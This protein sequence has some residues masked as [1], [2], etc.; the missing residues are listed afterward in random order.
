M[1]ESRAGRHSGITYQVSVVS[2]PAVTHGMTRQ[3]FTGM[4]IRA[5]NN[6]KKRAPMHNYAKRPLRPH[7]GTHLKNSIETSKIQ[8]TLFPKGAVL[9]G[10]VASSKHYAYF[11]DQGTKPFMAKVLPPWAPG[12]PTLFEHTWTPPGSQRPVGKKLVRG[13]DAQL[14]FMHGLDDT[15]KGTKLTG[16]RAGLN[17]ASTLASWPHG[18]EHTNGSTTATPWRRASFIKRLQ[19]W[20]EWRDASVGEWM[21]EQREAKAERKL[22]AR[23]RAARQAEKQRLAEKAGKREADRRRQDE[24]AIAKVRQALKPSKRRD[25]LDEIQA[26]RDWLYHEFTKENEGSFDIRRLKTGEGVG[27][28]T[29]GSRE[30]PTIIGWARLAG[31][32]GSQAEWAKKRSEKKK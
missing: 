25:A 5:K 7:P 2:A 12:S 26:Y 24:K 15:M 28:R 17:M 18:L 30:N 4:Q 1:P 16:T 31:R 6:V 8:A 20:R 10:A 29:I 21:R 3:W 22:P 23:V 13:Q 27:V 19:E 11:V 9:Y 14:F 32:Y